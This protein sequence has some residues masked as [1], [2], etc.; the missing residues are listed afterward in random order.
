MYL[1]VVAGRFLPFEMPDL[2]GIPA[3]GIWTIILLIYAFIASVLP[4]TTLLQPRDFINAYQLVIAMGLIVLGILVAG[5]TV[6]VVYAS[7]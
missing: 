5:L 2:F 4:V 1:T 3:T 7:P 6:N